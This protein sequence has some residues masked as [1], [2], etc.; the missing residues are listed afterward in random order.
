MIG[1]FD[2]E[3]KVPNQLGAI[4]THPL[5]VDLLCTSHLC[6]EGIP[7]A[8]VRGRDHHVCL[9]ASLHDGEVWS[10]P[11]QVHGMLHDVP[12]L[13]GRKLQEGKCSVSESLLLERFCIIICFS[14]VWFCHAGVTAYLTAGTSVCRWI[15]YIFVGRSRHPMFGKEM[16]CQRMWTL[17]LPRSRP[18]VPFSSWTGAQ[19]ASSAVSTTSHQQWSP[20][21]TWPRSCVRAAWSPTPR[22]SRRS[23]LALITSSTSCSLAMLLNFE[24]HP[25]SYWFA[26]YVA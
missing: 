1:W 6:R 12:R 8:A 23:S 15:T 20:V 21:V 9:R 17:P 19:L 25:W 5:H 2:S 18:S 3:A 24:G 11:W 4:P 10:S 26:S 14:S 22:L 16:W 7:W 13:L